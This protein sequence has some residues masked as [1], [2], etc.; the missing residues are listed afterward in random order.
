MASP[1]IV[2]PGSANAVGDATSFVLRELT[3]Q[4]REVVLT[5]RALPYRPQRFS[6]KMRVQTTWYPGNPIATQQVLGSEEG[7]TSFTG[8]W[9]DRFISQ[10]SVGT[11]GATPARVAGRPVVDVMDLVMSIDDIRRQGQQVEVTWDEVVRVGVITEFTPSWHS[12]TDVEWTLTI[13]WGS[14]GE[15]EP[16]HQVAETSIGDAGAELLAAAGTLLDT[17][18]P[19]GIA[20][21]T[22]LSGALPTPSQQLADLLQTARENLLAAQDVAQ[23]VTAGIQQIYGTVQVINDIAAQAVDVVLSPVEVA[24]S[25]S[26]IFDVVV[27]VARGIEDA[28]RSR[29]AAQFYYVSPLPPAPPGPASVPISTIT[30]GQAVLAENKARQAIVAAREMRYAA[31]RRRADFADKAAPGEMLAVFVAR[32][33]ADLRVVAGT[34]YGRQEEWRSLA[35]YNGLSGSALVAGQLVYVPRN[36]QTQRRA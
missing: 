5:E 16:Q 33:G 26:G 6:G 12:R 22:T 3:G 17:S 29:V 1:N 27:G 23:Q 21:P 28:F 18:T 7:S 19:F 32:D 2:A 25:A 31:A 4:Q 14:Q 10:A 11:A 35:R 30:S 9:K 13:E 8:F 36:P 34:Y 15:A 24:R 20:L